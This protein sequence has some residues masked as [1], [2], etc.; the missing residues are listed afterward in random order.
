MTQDE[1]YTQEFQKALNDYIELGFNQDECNGFM[2][3][4]H[5]G[6][7]AKQLILSGVSKCFTEKQMDEAYDKGY[8]D[9]INTG[10]TPM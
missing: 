2:H 8:T 6:A 3:G 10:N 5:K 7:E 1:K 9:G 4:F